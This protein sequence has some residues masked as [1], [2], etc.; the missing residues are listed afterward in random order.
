MPNTCPCEPIGTYDNS[1][2]D[3]SMPALVINRY[4]AVSFCRLGSDRCL[5][6]RRD[7]RACIPRRIQQYCV[8]RRAAYDST[9]RQ[10]KLSALP[11]VDQLEFVNLSRKAIG[12][13]IV[14]SQLS[15]NVHCSA[16]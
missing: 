3:Q 9:S 12:H 16:V 14:Q 11:T 4:R 7:L 13:A 6:A 2:T 8:K 15:K 10:A 1:S 5:R